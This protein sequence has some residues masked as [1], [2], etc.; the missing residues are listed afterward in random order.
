MTGK[1]RGCPAGEECTRY[2][3]N[4]TR[5]SYINWSKFKLSYDNGMTDKQIAEVIGCKSGVVGK[6]LKLGGRGPN[7]KK[8][9][10][11]KDA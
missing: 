11:E 10:V 9:E 7:K 5:R 8:K 1:R 2:S 4:R 3:S 6:Y